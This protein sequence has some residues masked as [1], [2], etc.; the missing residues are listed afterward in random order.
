M[1]HGIRLVAALCIALWTPHALALDEDSLQRRG[2]L[3]ARLT[4]AEGAEGGVLVLEVFPDTAAADAGLQADDRLVRIASTQIGTQNAVPDAVAAIAAHRAG[5]AMAVDFIR[6][7]NPYRAEVTLR[8]IPQESAP[9]Y[10]TEYG[11]VDV[12]GA[13]HRTIV[14]KPRSEGPHTAV[15]FVQGLGCSSIEYPVD[16]DNPIRQLIAG[17]TRAG[18]ATLRVEKSG[19]GDSQ[20]PPCDSIDFETE[21]DGYRAALTHLLSRDD[22]D[23]ERVFIFGHSMGG[24]FGPVLAA[25]FPL[26][27]VAV[28]GTIAAPLDEYFPVNDTRQM[29]LRGMSDAAIENRQAQMTEFIER[30]FAERQTPETIA[31]SSARMAAFLRIRSSGPETFHGR[32]YT[33]WRQLDDLDL[34]TPWREVPCPVLALWGASDIA[35]TRDD[36][37][38]IAAIVN[39][40][41]PGAARFVEIPETGHGFEIAATMEDSQSRRSTGPFNERIVEITVEWLNGV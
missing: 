30:F 26:A 5:E 13:L 16:P 34:P 27:G 24:V 12:N 8:P 28:Y 38:R 14:T 21:L 32:H 35:A 1:T 2:F 18:F 40:Q 23:P 29:R 4:P 6:G 39:E 41:H 15:F 10:D 33:F 7:E 3:G 20:G 36:H 31:A 37:P 22:V 17:F 11:S 25:E 19:I 9:D